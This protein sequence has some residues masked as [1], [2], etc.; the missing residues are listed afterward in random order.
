MT[1]E[2]DEAALEAIRASEPDPMGLMDLM[3]LIAPEA[4]VTGWHRMPGGGGTAMHRIDVTMPSGAETAFVLRRFLPETGQDGATA[5]REAATLE[6]LRDTMVAAPDVLWLDA[7]GVVFGRP[8]LAMTLLPGRPRTAEVA[9]DPA[10]LRGLA[11]ALVSLRWV[12]LDAVEHLPAHHDVA[13]LTAAL[14]DATD[15]PTSDLVDT[16]HVREV[17]LAHADRVAPEPAALGHGD[18]H[19]GNVLFDGTRPVGI[20]D[21]THARIADPRADVTY[22]AFD[23]ALV[24]G[25]EVAEAFL[26][27][28]A[29]LRGDMADAAWWRL[30]A[31]TSAF[32]DP[33]SWIPAWHA[34]GVDVTEEQVLD[35]YVAW[36][37][38]ALAELGP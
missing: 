18:F 20:V 9:G 36:V 26:A 14:R 31:A 19:V 1:G 5:T 25:L 7:D 30:R 16:H 38:A 35:R 13:A 15:L 23:L 34:L 2:P 32:P 12:P 3:E 22:C 21:W 17:V 27:E 33:R 28:H 4:R 29:A 10:L 11:E 6:A 24:A 37:E 8:A